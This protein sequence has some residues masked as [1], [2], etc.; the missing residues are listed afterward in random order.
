VGLIHVIRGFGNLVPDSPE[1]LMPAENVEL[2]HKDMMRLFNDVKGKLVLAGFDE[3]RIEEKIITGVYS[4]AGA[5]VE[6]AEAGDYGAIVVGRKGLSR[7]QEFFMGQVSMKVIHEG[8][9]FTVWM[10]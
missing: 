6:A 8:K 5:I 4:R 10:V 7:V 3:N 1:F 9:K 2:A